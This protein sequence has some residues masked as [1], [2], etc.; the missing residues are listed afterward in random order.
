VAKVTDIESPRK[1]RGV[2]R[3]KSSP[4]SPSPELMD[5]ARAAYELMIGGKSRSE[6][7]EILGY[8]HAEDVS[9]LMTQRF[10]A[11]SSHLSAQET[12]DI[13]ALETMRLD[14]LQAAVWPAAMMGDP[15]SVDSAVKIILARM[16]VNNLDQVDPVVNKQMI[17]VM[18]DKEE[19]YIAALKAAAD[20]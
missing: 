6:I 11:D 5:K 14:A 2:A 7:S 1:G 20:D 8:E 15:K 16:R 10:A 4:R 3:S 17:L 13:R 9:R 18:G 19:D 12:K